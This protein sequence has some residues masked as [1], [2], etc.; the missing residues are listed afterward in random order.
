MN[1]IIIDPQTKTIR[2]VDVKDYKDALREA[3]LTSGGIDFG[4][5]M[6]ARDGTTYTTMVYEWGLIR[7]K[8]DAYFSILKSLYCG[9]AVV[10]RANN[11]GETI[12]IPLS[13]ADH[14]ATG[15]CP[16]FR[17]IGTAQDA[18]KAIQ[19]GHIDRPQSSIN[20]QVTWQWR[21]P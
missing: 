20:G 7:P 4:T 1:H 6:R 14:W 21:A 8:V 16:D 18:E 17:W 3:G 13:L 9:P 5:V 15:E 10:F 12:D 11:E 2:N 19:D